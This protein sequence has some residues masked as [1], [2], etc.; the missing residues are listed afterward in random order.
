[1]DD[2]QVR[3]SVVGVRVE[4]PSNQPVLILRGAAPEDLKHHV[5]IVV[6]PA[7]AAAVARALQGETPVRPMTHDL[8]AESLELLGGGVVAIELGLLD[9]STYFGSIR[10][11]TGQVLDARASDAV[12]LAVRVHCPVTMSRET[13]WKSRSHRATVPQLERTKNLTA[14]QRQEPTKDC[15]TA[16][17][18]SPRKRSD[19]SIN[20][21]MRR[22]PKILKIRNTTRRNLNAILWSCADTLD[23][24]RKHERCHSARRVRK[25]TGESGFKR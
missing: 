25:V 6:G 24:D 9:P 21:W 1:M 11:G 8:L 10:L 5:A 23:K 22:D 4:L 16:G 7:E 20:S 12:A 18:R 14:R 2:R 15:P 13:L 3:L 19:S 17:A